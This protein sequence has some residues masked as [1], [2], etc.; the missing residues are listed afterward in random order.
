[1]VNNNTTVSWF[2]RAVCLVF[3][4]ARAPR[5]G[6]GKGHPMMKLQICT[7]ALQG[8]QGNDHGTQRQSPSLP[9]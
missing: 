9:P 6:K 3:E 2:Y 8:H 7:G 1:M 4:K 5:H